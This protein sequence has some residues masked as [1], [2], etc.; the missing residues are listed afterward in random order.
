MSPSL[1]GSRKI[2][3]VELSR[4]YLACSIPGVEV[5]AGKFFLDLD[6]CSFFREVDGIACLLDWMRSHSAARE[7]RDH[8]TTYSKILRIFTLFDSIRR[9]DA[10]CNYDKNDRNDERTNERVVRTETLSS[11]L[12]FFFLFFSF[13]FFPLSFFSPLRVI[14]CRVFHK[15]DTTVRFYQRS[16]RYVK[17]PPPLSHL[18]DRERRERERERRNTS[19]SKIRNFI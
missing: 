2:L 19:R 3:I 9:T 12:L 4:G 13:F 6:N 5:H 17:I 8:R 11:S 14:P 7:S 15:T 16:F 18:P 10:S 1:P